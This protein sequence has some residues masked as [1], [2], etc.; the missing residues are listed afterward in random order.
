MENL[1]SLT[2]RKHFWSEFCRELLLA[3]WLTEHAV[4]KNKQK[5]N[6]KGA[7]KA[8]RWVSQLEWR[9]NFFVGELGVGLIILSGREVIFIS[10]WCSST[11]IGHLPGSLV[12]SEPRAFYCG[13]GG[14]RVYKMSCCVCN[15][16]QLQGNRLSFWGRR[17]SHYYC[18]QYRCTLL[19]FY[20]L[21]TEA[22][23]TKKKCSWNCTVVAS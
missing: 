3:L 1:C 14:W 6:N 20:A 16:K 18:S 9:L 21:Q 22:T 19:Y 15:E 10:S 17:R 4:K 7:I 2:V 13:A 11:L 12:G 8:F 23:T 5:E